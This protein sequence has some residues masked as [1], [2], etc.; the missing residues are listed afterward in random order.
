MKKWFSLLVVILLIGVVAAVEDP[1][2]S[3]VGV[4]GPDVGSCQPSYCDYDNIEAHE[5]PGGEYCCSG[6][7]YKGFE[8]CTDFTT[9]S[10][11]IVNP[12]WPGQSV[13]EKTDYC[14]DSNILYEAYID[15]EFGGQDDV[16]YYV[17]DCRD[18]SYCTSWEYF[19]ETGKVRRKR[20]CVDW[21]CDDGKCVTTGF[22]WEYQLVSQNGYGSYCD[23][24]KQGYDEGWDG[25]SLCSHGEYDCDSDS[26]CSGNLECM[27]PIGDGDSSKYDGCCKYFE[28]WDTSRK[29]CCECSEGVCCDGCH[30]YGT[31]RVC[32]YHSGS[33][34]YGCGNGNC[35]GDDV[36]KIDQRRYCSGDSSL[37]GGSE[38]WNDPIIHDYCNSGEFCDGPDRSYS[39]D[40]KSCKSVQ[41]TAGKCC[42][43]SCGNYKIRPSSY[44]CIDDLPWYWCPWGTDLGDDVGR[45]IGD[46]YCDGFT[47]ACNGEFVWQPWTT[48]EDCNSQQ[49]CEGEPS[50]DLIACEDIDCSSDSDCTGEHWIRI[51]CNLGDV[52]GDFW[53]ASCE[54]PGTK[55]SDCVYQEVYK[56]KEECGSSGYEGN[57]YCLN[58]NGQPSVYQRY[59]TRWCEP[60]CR[61]STEERRLEICDAG[62]TSGT[63]DSILEGDTNGDCKVDIFDLAR[64]GL[65]YGEEC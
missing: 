17:K 23:Y 18:F 53:Q 5:G 60:G 56:K 38:E 20:Q 8:E 63:C 37:C 48:Y 10:T 6:V 4:F 46:R 49:Y 36:Y 59:I 12:F 13:K 2:Y 58:Y 14:Q 52:W 28:R 21:G 55:E 45:K 22:D 24:R 35:Q 50:P 47:D 44:V 27:G 61:S 42:D 1:L 3:D 11:A 32:D 51:E 25:C 30:Y 31:D 26:E 40:E 19:C 16:N 65:H 7:N 43:A 64:V 41:C 54:N 33:Y 15:C 29:E 39:Y 62:C 9:R 57:R 34:Q